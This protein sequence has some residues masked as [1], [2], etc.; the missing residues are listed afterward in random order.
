MREMI[1]L[2]CQIIAQVLYFNMDKQEC[3]QKK[4]HVQMFGNQIEHSCH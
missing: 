2:S 1:S 4:I 3:L